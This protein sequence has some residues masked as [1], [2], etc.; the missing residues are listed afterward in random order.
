MSDLVRDFDRHGTGYAALLRQF[1]RNEEISNSLIRPFIRAELAGI[2]RSRK[3]K[4]GFLNPG[5][6]RIVIGIG[7]LHLNMDRCGREH[8]EQGLCNRFGMVLLF[9]GKVR[10]RRGIRIVDIDRL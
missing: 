2:G 1:F 7:N 8:T 9:S 3:G 6:R 4:L 5:G 10:I